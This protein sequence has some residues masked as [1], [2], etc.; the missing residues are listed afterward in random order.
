MLAKFENAQNFKITKISILALTILCLGFGIVSGELENIV[1]IW[2]ITSFFAHN[3]TLVTSSFQ[4]RGGFKPIILLL[5]GDNASHTTC[6]R[7]DANKVN[8]KKRNWPEIV[9]DGFDFA[10]Q[11]VHS[12]FSETVFLAIRYMVLKFSFCNDMCNPS[13]TYCFLDLNLG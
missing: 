3:Y 5:W 12:S 4:H 2:A 8:V 6:Q 11:P 9:P 7:V 10:F 1:D 13:N